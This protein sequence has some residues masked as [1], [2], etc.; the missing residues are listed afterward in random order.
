MSRLRWRR[1]LIAACSRDARSRMT[2]W[3]ERGEISPQ[4]AAACRTRS[5][6]GID[7]ADFVHV[8]LRTAR[9]I[10]RCDHQVARL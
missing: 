1:V 5:D 9:S 6:R 3:S 2:T 10:G 4:G 8:A 7:D